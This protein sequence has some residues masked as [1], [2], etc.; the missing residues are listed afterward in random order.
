MTAK[1]NLLEP[2]WTLY[3][4]HTVRY[5]RHGAQN[6][7]QEIYNFLLD[8]M[9]FCGQKMYFQI[10]FKRISDSKMLKS[11]VPYEFFAII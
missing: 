9:A 6:K 11:F 8:T 7:L 2:S 1:C 10:L 5:A 3:W 4:A